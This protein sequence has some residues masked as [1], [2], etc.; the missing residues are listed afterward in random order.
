MI[1]IAVKVG[2]STFTD[3]GKNK[4]LLFSTQLKLKMKI[5]LSLAIKV[6]FQGK[7]RNVYVKNEC[8]YESDEC[9]YSTLRSTLL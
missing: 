5:E 3:W 7:E 4:S 2:L 8:K 1:R 9:V 6:N